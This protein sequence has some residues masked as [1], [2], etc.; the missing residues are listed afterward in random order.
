M[1]HATTNSKEKEKEEK[2]SSKQLYHISKEAFIQ[3][4]YK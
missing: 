1:L 2:W 3:R 4:Y